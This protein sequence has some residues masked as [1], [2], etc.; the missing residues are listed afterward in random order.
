MTDNNAAFIQAY[1]VLKD[2]INRRAGRDGSARL[3]IEDAIDRDQRVAKRA[4]LIRSIMSIRNILQ[5]PHHTSRGPAFQITREFLAETT[6]LVQDLQNPPRASS[7][8]IPRG[9]LCVADRGQ[10]VASIADV[11]RAKR[12]SHIPILDRKDVLI[13]VFNEA[14]IFDYFFS[15]GGKEKASALTIEDI[16]AHCRLD[17]EHTET[18]GFVGPNATEDAIIA[19]LTAIA[20]PSTRIGAL[21]V[22]ASGKPSEPITGMLTPWDVLA[23]RSA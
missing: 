13:G 10:T 1:E 7:M 8:C 2:E 4:R 9:K 18:F 15:N 22:T 6:D 3:E 21:F 11:M 5:H 20:G 14:A 19:R 12:F 23:T 16:L 17:A